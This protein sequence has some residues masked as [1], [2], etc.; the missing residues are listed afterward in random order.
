MNNLIKLLDKNL[1]Y[2]EHEIID[3]SIYPDLRTV[4]INIIQ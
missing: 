4:I 1:E 2:I 3:D